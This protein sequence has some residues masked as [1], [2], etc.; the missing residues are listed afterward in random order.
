MPHAA[1]RPLAWLIFDV[2]QD[3]FAMMS[4]SMQSMR[5]RGDRSVGGESR[6]RAS[7]FGRSG[8]VRL[9]RPG[10][11]S[12]ESAERTLGPG[13]GLPAAPVRCLLPCAF[14]G[15][16]FAFVPMT[17]SPFAQHRSNRLSPNKAPEPTPVAVMPRAIEGVIESD[18]RNPSRSAARVL[19]ATGVAH[20]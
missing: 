12:W 4:S 15:D 5:S 3:S 8:R 16:A 6:S 7:I 13:F 2:R 14:S 1:C 9:H 17:R 19:P 18:Q 10:A 11:P 20:L